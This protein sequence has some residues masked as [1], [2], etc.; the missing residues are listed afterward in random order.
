MW[1]DLSGRRSLSLS[2]VPGA[3][4]EPEPEWRSEP[5][6]TLLSRRSLQLPDDAVGRQ[7]YVRPVGDCTLPF[8]LVQILPSK[9]A[10]RPEF[11][12]NES[13]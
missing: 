13:S 4:V 2:Y 6:R 8:L 12:P 10:L 3:G 11:D 7:K 1:S 5:L 9:G